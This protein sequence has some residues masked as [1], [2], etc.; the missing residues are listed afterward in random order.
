MKDILAHFFWTTVYIERVLHV[1]CPAAAGIPRFGSGLRG[2]QRRV[3][4]TAQVSRVRA[5]DPR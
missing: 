1:Y 5:A 4:S 2:R 3:V